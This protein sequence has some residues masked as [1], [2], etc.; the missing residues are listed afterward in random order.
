MF[1]KLFDCEEYG[2]LLVKI[3]ANDDGAPEV[4]VFFEPD[5]LGVCSVG[6]SYE[7]SDEGW[8]KAE[9]SFDSFTTESAKAVVKV[10]L[11]SINK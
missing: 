10:A 7:D 9:E 4:R 8:D 5:G 1:A 2:Q 6:L 3:D 11:N